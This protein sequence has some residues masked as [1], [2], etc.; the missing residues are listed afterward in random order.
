MRVIAGEAGGSVL[1][2]PTGARPTAGRVR[3]ALFSA[4]GDLRGATVLDLYAGSGALGIEELSRGA[5]RAVLVDRDRRAVDACTQNLATT[6]LAAR[7]RVDGRA[8]S[9]VLAGAPPAEAPFDLVCCDPPYEAAE[10]EVAL[11]VGALA[12]PGW[13]HPSGRLV[14]ERRARARA[15]PEPEWGS[16]WP[17]WG[18]EWE[19]GWER[20]Y[21][22]TLVTVLRPTQT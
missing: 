14:L 17:E 10:S 15:A 8:V 16:G 3:E 9:T 6:R 18:A 7:A 2:A 20:R 4:L 5:D 1:V 13:L 19:V 12:R 11:V 21:G 22:D